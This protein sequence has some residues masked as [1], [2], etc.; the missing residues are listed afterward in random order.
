MII[1]L[2]LKPIHIIGMSA[3]TMAE[4]LLFITTTYEKY[5]QRE[6]LDKMVAYD[7]C[8]RSLKGSMLEL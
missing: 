2:E 1:K 8:V 6:A 7:R 5:R 3:A 4:N